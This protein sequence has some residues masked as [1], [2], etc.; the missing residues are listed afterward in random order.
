MA[1]TETYFESNSYSGLF[2]RAFW[3]TGI[4]ERK[5][6][7]IILEIFPVLGTKKPKK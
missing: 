3:S 4:L 2:F 6:K 5:I 7:K 1:R